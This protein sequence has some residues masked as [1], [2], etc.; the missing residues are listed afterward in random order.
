MNKKYTIRSEFVIPNKNKMS[1]VELV[2]NFTLKN[3]QFFEDEVLKYDPNE[4]REVILE[5]A[6]TCACRGS[7]RRLY[8]LCTLIDEQ[9][10]HYVVESLIFSH[11]FTILFKLGSKIGLKPKM[12]T[13]KELQALRMSSESYVYLQD[14]FWSDF[15]SEVRDYDPSI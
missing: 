8:A 7:S 11:N 6:R 1:L 9:D 5:T 3:R 10:M 14:P 12:F 2:S 15:F 13:A 4:V